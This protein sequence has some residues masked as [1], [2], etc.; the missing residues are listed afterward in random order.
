MN[1]LYDAED[2]AEFHRLQKIKSEKEV[3]NMNAFERAA[4]W[5]I[6]SYDGARAAGID[7]EEQL[8]WTAKSFRNAF[9]DVPEIDTGLCSAKAYNNH[10][11]K[12]SKLNTHDH[13]NSRTKSSIEFMNFWREGRFRMDNLQDAVEFMMEK[14]H[15][16]TITR[17]ENTDLIPIQNNEETMH[18][19]YMQQ[20][21]LLHID[22]LYLKPDLRQKWIYTI[23]DVVYDN[24]SDAA[25]AKGCS[26][27]T[28]NNRCK[29]QSKKY[30]G[31][32]R[33]EKK[34]EPIPIPPEKN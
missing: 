26:I 31:W 21:N 22:K 25:R 28:L 15:V 6:T 14:A 1:I 7:T 18:L 10:I 11:A 24:T 9:F 33:T 17:T 29:S 5:M 13:F 30:A 23:D 2:I 27:A 4:A 32:V 12:K 34:L 16:H 3:E 19:P 8:I 20:Y